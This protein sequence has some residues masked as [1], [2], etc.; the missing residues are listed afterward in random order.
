M[1]PS[2]WTAISRSGRSSDSSTSR[3]GLVKPALVQLSAGST[4]C[5]QAQVGAGAAR[6]PRASRNAPTRDTSATASASVGRPPVPGGCNRVPSDRGAE[7]G[8]IA[9]QRAASGPGTAPSSDAPGG[10]GEQPAAHRPRR[11]D[12]LGAGMAARRSEQHEADDLDEAVDR[13]CSGERQRGQGQRSRDAGRDAVRQREMKQRLQRQPLRDE[14]VQR[15]D[16]GDRPGAD[17]EGG[18]GPGHATQQAAQAIQL[19]V[20]DGALERA[21]AE[22]QERL[23]DGV[24]DRV[25]QRRGERHARPAGL[26][27]LAQ[28]QRGAEA[29]QDDADV[30]DRVQR[31]Q[32]LQL[33]LEEGVDDSAEGR[34]RAQRD[35]RHAEPERRP[36]EPL[37]EHAHEAVQ[38]DLDHH[39][40]HERRDVRGGE[41]VRARQPDVQRHHAR[42][43]AEADQRGHRDQRAAGRGGV[44]RVPAERAVLGQ[45]EQRHP[46]PG[47]RRGA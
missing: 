32:A 29:E 31:E 35:H 42:L 46:R 14:A 7:P 45:H 11:L 30:L 6:R 25:Q 8:R 40:A 17:Q 5:P 33:M 47:A 18:A 37:E 19:E 36:V 23:E 34:D 41:R 26:T 39:A 16:P 27:L 22:E 24:V 28:D 21:G 15:R 12:G 13:E 4:R 20:V 3:T 2:T 44:E 9:A 38:R 43:G 1:P 10:Q